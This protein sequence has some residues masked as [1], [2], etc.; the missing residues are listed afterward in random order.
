MGFLSLLIMQKK[1][2]IIK[3]NN[4]ML[5]ILCTSCRKILK[6]GVDFSP[7]EWNYAKYKDSY[8]PPQYCD[9]CALKVAITP[10]LSN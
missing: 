10:I 8:L 2:A 7:E 1:K 9:K 4:S 5:A 3:W 6:T